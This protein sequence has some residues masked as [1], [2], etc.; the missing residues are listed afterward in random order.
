MEMDG[1]SPGTAEDGIGVFFA[2]EGVV[3]CIFADDANGIV[4][5]TA[6]QSV[7][8]FTAD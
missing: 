8:A 1:V 5:G 2:D 3:G 7:L 4:A 6:V